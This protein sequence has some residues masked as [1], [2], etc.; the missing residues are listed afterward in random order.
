MKFNK[1][2]ALIGLLLLITACSNKLVYRYSDVLIGWTVDDYVDWNKVQ[3]EDFDQ[4][5]DTLLLWH[6]ET[7]LQR[8][9]KWLIELEQLSHRN[10]SPK[11]LTTAFEPLQAFWRDILEFSFNDTQALLASL[12]D[13][14]VESMMEALWQSQK[15]S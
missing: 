8:Y 6:Q 15:D 7:Q 1:T 4:A 5:I 9:Q 12:S 10:P 2:L 3:Q 11:Q 14:Q 13:E